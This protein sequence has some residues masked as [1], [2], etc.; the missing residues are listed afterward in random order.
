AGN[1]GATGVQSAAAALEHLIRDRSN[2]QDMERARQHVGAVLEPL[3]AGIRAAFAAVES[4]ASAPMPLAAPTARSRDAAA[5]LA[6]LLL[7]SDPG[8]ADFVDANRDP[9]RPFFDASSWS[10]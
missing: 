3:V 6:A 9:L 8:A 2:A 1:I 7:D 5:Q 4:D 10:E